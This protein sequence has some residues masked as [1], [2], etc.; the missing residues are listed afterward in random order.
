MT[1]APEC[2]RC[3]NP[4]RPKGRLCRACHAANMRAWRRKRITITRETFSA[5]VASMNKPALRS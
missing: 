3:N 1:A 4:R 5:L 2:S